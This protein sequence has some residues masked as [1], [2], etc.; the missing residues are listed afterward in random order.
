MMFNTVCQ[1]TGYQIE[2][3]LQEGHGTPTSSACLDVLMMQWISWAGYPKRIVTDRGLN[4]RGIFMKE[5]S[6]AGVD[7]HSIGLEA[8]YQ[9]AKTER[10]GGMWCDIAAKVIEEREIRGFDQMRRMA[11]EVNA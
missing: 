8:P 1:G 9:L 4:N 2:V 6:A 3:V 11:A 10:H 7:T 5:M